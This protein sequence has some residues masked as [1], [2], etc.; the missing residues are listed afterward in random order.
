MEYLLPNYK[1]FYFI[2][3]YDTID[4]NSYSNLSYTLQTYSQLFLFN[5]IAA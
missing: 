1:L 3:H 4:H 5:Y 2:R